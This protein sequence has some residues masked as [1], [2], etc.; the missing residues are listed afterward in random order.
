MSRMWS[1]VQP[2]VNGFILL[3]SVMDRT[4]RFHVRAG[5]DARVESVRPGLVRVADAASVAYLERRGEKVR[6]LWPPRD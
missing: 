3:G 6:K 4:G 1:G 5:R 2:S